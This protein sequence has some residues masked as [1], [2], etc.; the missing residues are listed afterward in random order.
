MTDKKPSSS[1]KLTYKEHKFIA[2]MTDP[3]SDTYLHQTRSAKAAYNVAPSNANKLGSQIANRPRVALA[4]KEALS[5]KEI[6][7]LVTEGVFERLKDPNSRHWQP[8]ADFVAK[9]RGDFAPEKH[10]NVNLDP[11]DRDK[12][13]QE[14]L[15]LIDKKKANTNE[16]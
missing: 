7:E 16:V 11:V 14:I 2:A 8:T 15:D 9:L 10:V 4:L 5:C 12:K 1:D 6:D 13:Y 3:N